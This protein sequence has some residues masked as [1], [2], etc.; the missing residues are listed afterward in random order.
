MA[1]GGGDGRS[2]GGQQRGDWEVGDWVCPGC[3]AINFKRRSS[4]LKCGAAKPEAFEQAVPYAPLGDGKK[5][6]GPKKT[7]G[8]GDEMWCEL[9]LIECPGQASYTE[10]CRGKKHRA[11]LRA[12]SGEPAPAVTCKP[13]GDEWSVAVKKSNAKGS[14]SSSGG[15]K[16]GTNGGANSSSKH[17]EQHRSNTQPG[18]WEQGDWV[19]SVCR[20]INFKKRDTC[21]KCPNIVTQDNFEQAQPY[22]QPGESKK[23]VGMSQNASSGSSKERP[24]WCDLCKVECP[25]EISFNEH[26]AG[27]KHLAKVRQ[28]RQSMPNRTGAG[29]AKS[30]EVNIAL[31]RPRDASW[32][33]RTE[34]NS[35]YKLQEA[36]AAAEPAPILGGLVSKKKT[37]AEALSGGSKPAVAEEPPPSATPPSSPPQAQI[38]EQQQ[39]PMAGFG[40]FAL[41]QPP[42]NTGPSSNPSSPAPEWGL[43]GSSLWGLPEQPKEAGLGS[44]LWAGAGLGG[45]EEDRVGSASGSPKLTPQIQPSSSWQ[46]ENMPS[47][48]DKPAEDIWGKS[49][50]SAAV[51]GASYQGESQQFF[52][53]APKDPP[54]LGQDES[55]QGLHAQPRGEQ[56]VADEPVEGQWNRGQWDVKEEHSTNG[57]IG[58]E[59]KQQ[60]QPQPQLQQQGI[61]DPTQHFGAAPTVSAGPG[62]GRIVSWDQQL[63]YAQTCEGFLVLISLFDINSGAIPAQGQDVRWSSLQQDGQGY[64]AMN[65]ELLGGAN[66]FGSLPQQQQQTRDWGQGGSLHDNGHGGFDQREEM[67]WN[68]PSHHGYNQQQHY[69]GNQQHSKQ[70]YGQ[71][72]PYQQM[73]Q[74]PMGYQSQHGWGS[75]G[76]MS[77]QQQ[78]TQPGYNSNRA[79]GGGS[80]WGNP[81]PGPGGMVQPGTM[82]SSGQQYASQP[83]QNS[84]WSHDNVQQHTTMPWGGAAPR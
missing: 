69:M 64:R 36:A 65:V 70:G 25:G 23:H 10:H 15:A 72:M 20:W 27:K 28:A 8:K 7:G 54:Q 71:H 22:V 68:A 29:R 32:D 59:E 58:V 21:L 57:H 24:R 31:P 60:Q 76:N 30:E 41:D 3:R 84:V 77:W 78:Y 74:P 67:S 26:C 82:K 81:A 79:F 19:C 55:I 11:A 4:C 43:G 47:P 61:W 17:A 12:M 9:C 48:K 34:S 14:N 1:T 56:Q 46:N 37:F 50:D 33:A 49:A 45:F 38:P 83:Q 5:G 39:V 6:G 63:G 2:R 35:T 16:G 51:W 52:E 75:A 18:E 62:S 66:D 42:I 73:Q 80:Y 53:D 13:V 44:D 40:S